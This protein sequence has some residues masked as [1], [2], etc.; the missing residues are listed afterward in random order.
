MSF[1]DNISKLALQISQRKAHVINEETT[2]HSLIIPFI[3]VLGNLVK[4][5]YCYR[6]RTLVILELQKETPVPSREN[7]VTS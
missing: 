6:I 5:Y 7:E 4:I 3:Q 1:K 2:K